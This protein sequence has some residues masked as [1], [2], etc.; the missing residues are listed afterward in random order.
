MSRASVN[1]IL[2]CFLLVAFLFVLWTSI[3]LRAIFPD[4]TQADGWTVWGLTYDTW[5]TIQFGALAVLA[6]AIL[7]HLILHWAW[8]C[9]FLAHKL[10]IMRKRPIQ[11]PN[12]SL[13]TVY[14]VCT[15]IVVFVL[16][17]T[18]MLAAEFS[19]TAPDSA[20]G[21]PIDRDSGNLLR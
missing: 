20:P 5:A 8:I 3:L 15:L 11:R 12:D 4:P 2:D 19:T 6:L 1:F 16:L 14:G 21:T 10:S 18:A 17:G 9:G 7:L 13:I